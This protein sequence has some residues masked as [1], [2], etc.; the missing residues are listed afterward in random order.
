MKKNKLIKEL[1]FLFLVVLIVLSIIYLKK[2]LHVSKS[3]DYLEN[4]IVNMYEEDDDKTLKFLNKSYLDE[5]KDI[6]DAINFLSD[7][8]VLDEFY[9]N[10]EGSS[11]GYA[12]YRNA[13]L[14]IFSNKLGEAI[15]KL[16]SSSEQGNIQ[17]TSFL[18][19][20]LYSLKRYKEAYEYFEKAIEL[21]DY[22]IYSTYID[23]KENLE[24][25]LKMEELFIKYNQ[26]KISD[27]ERHKLGNFL[28]NIDDNYNAYKVLRPFIEKEDVVALYSKAMYLE[29]EGEIEEALEIHKDLVKKY[30]YPK[31]ALKI[32][33]NSDIST[34]SKRNK[35]IE[36]LNQVSNFD[37]D[38]EFIKA[39]LLFEND[40]WL[41]AK[42]IYDNLYESKYI[43]VYKKL[44][45]YYENISESEKALKMYKL[46]FETGDIDS[47]I[48]I[49]N[50]VESK[51]I[52]P[53]KED[54]DYI[55]Y[56]EIASKL[57]LSKASYILSKIYKDNTYLEKKYSILALAQGEIKGLENL[58]YLANLEGDKE[59]IKVFTNILINNK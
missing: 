24:E 40:K 3:F 20:Y 17:A 50:M 25:Y 57:G 9:K 19:N 48:N 29:M 53:N 2:Y 36:L 54:L 55:N 59:K 26:N 42:E 38:V 58:L 49:Y 45:K 31:S 32:V 18:A 44:A 14:L 46:S 43:P 28:T 35:A 39:N 7:E 1:L 41:E 23:M 5:D 52:D 16:K 13:T 27:I 22:T 11:Y 4:A 47:S 56:L 21:N 34:V 15:E 30:K 51:E 10:K 6:Y 12:E 33:E 37:N 8:K